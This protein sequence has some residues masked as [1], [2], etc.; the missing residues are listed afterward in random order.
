MMVD[1]LGLAFA[2]G[3]YAGQ[4]AA[5]TRPALRFV[6]QIMRKL[7]E[8]RGFARA[9]QGLG[10][11]AHAV[12]ADRAP[13]AGMRRRMAPRAIR[14][15]SPIDIDSLMRQPDQMTPDDQKNSEVRL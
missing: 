1:T 4:L 6:V 13:P 9:A 7:E 10:G 8:Q 14:G 2:D 5:L 15:T 3:G 11:G 12:Q